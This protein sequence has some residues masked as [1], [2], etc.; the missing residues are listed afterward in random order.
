MEFLK[1]PI[2]I[3]LTSCNITSDNNIT[4]NLIIYYQSAEPQAPKY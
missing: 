2:P 3:M 1:Y 4:Q